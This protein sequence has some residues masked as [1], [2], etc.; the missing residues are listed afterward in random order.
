MSDSQR[1]T[2]RRSPKRAPAVRASRILT[3]VVPDHPPIADHFAR[4][5]DWGLY[6]NDRYG[7]CG[8][9]SLANQRKL[10]T[11]YLTGV[12]SSPDQD[13]VYDLYRRSG[14]PGFDP[15]T[16]ADDNGVDMQTMLEAAVAGGI[17]GVTPLGFAAVDHTSLEEIRAAVAVFGS[18]L[19]GVS[20]ETAQEGQT[21]AGGP[22]DYKRSGEWGGHAVLG[23]RY[24]DSP[25]DRA[26][27]TGVV[28]WA[29]LIDMTDA[30]VSH[31]LEEVWVVVWPEHL[32]DAT[33]LA[34][35]DLEALAADYEALTGRP[36]PAPVPA[37]PPPPPPSDPLRALGELL[38]QFVSDV[39]I[40]LHSHGL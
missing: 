11:G 33:F 8:P 39:N 4:V 18:V 10:V 26:D 7:V 31:Q 35:V 13:A 32:S 38:K 15:A 17:G 34:G 14:N 19:Y 30:F 2:G 29:E 3:G 9:V 27:R 21:D 24:V 36:F 22:W 5:T 37:P 6:G 25:D 28:T 23:G 40:W 12:E 20:L 16:G 1:A